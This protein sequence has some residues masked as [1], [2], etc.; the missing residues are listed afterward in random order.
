[1]WRSVRK[2]G[3]VGSRFGGVFWVWGVGKWIELVEGGGED[4]AG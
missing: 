4:L 3:E 2:E 1:M